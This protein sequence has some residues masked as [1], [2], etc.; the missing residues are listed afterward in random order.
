MQSFAFSK[1]L[2]YHGILIQTLRV[3]KIT[4]I[5]L[6]L[7]CLQLSAAGYSQTITISV[8][9]APLV[10]LFKEINKQ[11]GYNFWYSNQ[12]LQKARTVSLDVKGATLKTVLEL[13]FKDQ[14]LDYIISETDKQVIV[15]LKK[16]NVTAPARGDSADNLIDVKG[17][18]LN[19][20]GEPV[21]GASI[22]VR[23]SAAGTST[24][25]NGEFIIKSV[26]ADATLLISG[27]NIESLEVK[28]TAKPDLSK[29]I[30]KIKISQGDEVIIGINTGYQKISKE[31]FVGSY[32]QLDSAAYNRRPGLDILSR[33]DGTV[34]GVLFDKKSTGYSQLKNIQIRGISTLEGE[35]S[36]SKAPLIVV[37]NFPF[38]QDLSAINPNDVESITVLKDAAAASIWGAQAGNGVIV[39]TTKKAKYNQAMHISVMSNLTIQE[40]PD[41][42]YYPQMSIPDFIDVE[43]FL[44]N[45]G[46][47]DGDLFDISRPVISPVVEIL[48][49]RR[50]G[51]LSA[52][53][54]ASQIDAFRGLDLRQ[55][56]SKY[57]YRPS[58]SQQHYIRLSGGNNLFSY[59]FSGGYNRSMN[60]IQNS[61]PDDQFTINSNTGFRP[62]K[63][64]EITTGINYSL[65]MGKSASFSLPGKIYP[66]AQLANAEGHPLPVP[67]DRR[68]AY[69]DTAGGGDLLDW[70]YFP[71]AEPA[72]TD[73]RDI[74]R[75]IVLNIG[76]Y[77]RF[78]SW[79]S[80]EA[81]YKYSNQSVNNRDYF[82]PETYFT[83]NLINQ[84]TNLSQTISDLRYP[85]PMGGIMDVLNQESNSQNARGQL[86]LNKNF[87]SKHQ[88]T[89]IAAG[90]V[91]E[92]KFE[93]NTNR[94][95]AYNK[96][97][98]AYKSEI[99]YRSSFPLYAGP[100]SNRISNES[101]PFF[102]SNRRFV[103]FLTNASYTYNSLYTVYASARKEGSNVFGVNTN[104]KWKPLWSAGAGW[105]I[106]KEIFYKIK[107]MPLLRLRA[108]Y[109]YTGNPGNA[110]GL[111]TIAYSGALA[112]FTNLP[113]AFPGN[114]PNPDLRWE[115]VRIINEAVDFSLF[116][117]RLTVG[118]EVW[119]KKS[120]DVISQAPFPPSTG[121]L[122]F[123]VN[124]ANLKGKGFDIN[125]NS[126]NVQ[127]IFKWETRFGLS[128]AKTIVTK[129]NG[130]LYR[131]QDFQSY[132]LNA[133]E[134]QIAFGIA[135]YKWAGLDPLT[136]DPLGYLNKQVSK[137]YGAILND[138]V[139]KQVFHG[140]A[141]PLY[142]GYIG[143]SF[144]WRNFTLSA[145][146]S[147]RFN[148]YFRRP[149]INYTE[150]V[151]SWQGHADYAMRWQKPG[152]EKYTN[153][154]SFTYPL[155]N[156][157]DLFYQNAEIN[158]LRGDNI[159]LQDVRLEY[160]WENRKQKKIPFKS[161][162]SFV[163][164]NNLNVILWRK[165]KSKLDPDFTGGVNFMAPPAK[166]WTAGINLS[167]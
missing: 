47:Y 25:E 132:G 46:K 64:L 153:V 74:Q 26:A 147:Y 158:V 164:V 6:T 14:V 33:L 13:C 146:I 138:S 81:S 12:D 23:G 82:S 152:N 135:S 119:Q 67:I 8:K 66:Y 76:I 17:R 145:N 31:R 150:L 163:Y 2:L 97:T 117:N 7:A 84:Y 166:T 100:S 127:G 161:I 68:L 87:G 62:V 29:L 90:E 36:P 21:A 148:F 154:P 155:D 55:D 130:N 114:P 118:A 70:R 58:I 141:I 101:I 107:W 104:K 89:A 69:T 51:K 144:S 52:A 63:N 10:K 86:N 94:F 41:L 96:E 28:L 88:I 113:S 83:R 48:A 39:I 59:S 125:L 38:R 20:N 18:V 49:K 75:L 78:T 110:T 149:T 109:G 103:S 126:K 35:N 91:S 15:Q 93:G 112:N 65:S 137:N 61:E 53:D 1:S 34:T 106:S 128:Y 40:K 30:A 99:D 22:R 24:N 92:T 133:A 160:N 98:G 19:E 121:T 165:N 167:F 124:Y 140:S 80:G 95:Y 73:R 45:K 139:E 129:L 134:G 72:L 60:N 151:N 79:L 37:D 162:Q 123:T 105:D 116:N 102:E 77:Y 42:Y 120:T 4:A 136:G 11:T 57:V 9:N 131:A 43:L 108:S 159:R 122:N 5:L 54:S 142:F 143:N 111:P 3:M 27:V 32:S 156:S 157:R 71:L 50:T 44:F 56:M 115:K 85:V 16:D